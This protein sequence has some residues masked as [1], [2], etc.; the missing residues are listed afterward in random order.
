MEPPT[1]WLELPTFNQTWQEVG[2]A[3]YSLA[4]ISNIQP[5]LVGGGWSLIQFDSNCLH[6]TRLGRR[7]V[8]PPA[9][10]HEL[11]TFNQSWQKVGGASYSLA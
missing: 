7:W 11:P 2:G 9:V 5:D 8:E 4:G 1:V 6:S 10:C 3:S